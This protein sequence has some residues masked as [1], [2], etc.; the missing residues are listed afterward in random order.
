MGKS[1]KPFFEGKV[2]NVYAGEEPVAQEM[3]NNTV[4]WMGDWKR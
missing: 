4:V 3:F 2:E 1:L